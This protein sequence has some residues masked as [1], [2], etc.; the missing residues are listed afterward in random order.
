M[1][2]LYKQLSETFSQPIEDF[3]IWSIMSRYNYTV[4]PLNCYELKEFA[5]RNVLDVCKQDTA[6]TIFVEAASDLSYSLTFDY[7]SLLQ[8]SKSQTTLD[9]LT[10][11]QQHQQQ[12][13]VKLPVFKQEEEV[14][15][16]FKY[17]DPKSSTLRYV[18]RMNLSKL[19]TLATIQER[20]N[21][22]MKFPLNTE[23]LFYEE[24]KISQI[25]PL[26][27]RDLPLLKLAHE[28]LLN[29]DIY[30]F[31]INEKEKLPNYKLPTVTD[32]FK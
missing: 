9:I 31:Q 26:T 4:R 18:F 13:L 23:L 16:F 5:N 25:T 17:Y 20:I 1:L 6:W 19:A 22:K 14:M 32:Y 11:Q 24:V 3:R 2:D 12:Q 10:L 7:Q 30:V 29:G 28:Q 8:A 27:V 15:I 21:K